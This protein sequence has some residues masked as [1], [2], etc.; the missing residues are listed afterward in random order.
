ML[1]GARTFLGDL[2]RFEKR[3]PANATVLPT[4]SQGRVYPCAAQGSGPLCG[5]CEFVR[6]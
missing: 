5:L 3:S 4:H 6:M 1:Y 2:S